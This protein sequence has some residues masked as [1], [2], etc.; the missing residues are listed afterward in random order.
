MKPMTVEPII[1]RGVLFPPGHVSITLNAD[2]RRAY[3]LLYGSAFPLGDV[4]ALKDHDFDG[5]SIKMSRPQLAALNRRFRALQEE[6]DPGPPGAFRDQERF[7]SKHF[8]EMQSL[9]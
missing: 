1:G 8:K 7:L 5:R 9:S 6:A 4:P 3:L 2:H